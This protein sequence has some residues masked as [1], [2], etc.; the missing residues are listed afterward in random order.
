MVAKQQVANSKPVG[1][2]DK[3]RVLPVWMTSI[4][5]DA[6]ATAKPKK[7]APKPKA[8]AKPKAVSAKRKEFLDD[9]EADDV[10]PPRKVRKLI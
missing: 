7:A 9:D 4:P 10:P 5:D 8:A 6:A 2:T 1:S 3:K